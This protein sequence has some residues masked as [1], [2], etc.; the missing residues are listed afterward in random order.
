M[1]LILQNLHPFLSI[2]ETKLLRNYFDICLTNDFSKISFQ[3]FRN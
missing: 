2:T 3:L 1:T